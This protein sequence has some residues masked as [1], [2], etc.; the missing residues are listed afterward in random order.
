MQLRAGRGD[1]TTRRVDAIVNAANSSLARG[2]GVCGAI[3]AAAGPDLDRACAAI[4]GCAT[5]DAVATPGF[6]L[7]ARWIIHAVG[8]VWRGGTD[9]EAGQLASCYRRV[10]AVAGEIGARSVAIPAISTGI[11]GFPGDQ[12]AEIAVTTLRAAAASTTPSASTVDEVL[13]VAFDE[14]TAERYEHLL[15]SPD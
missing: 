11:F 12:A 14:A 10:L 9:D 4:G 7:P 15:A 13:L 3:F 6:E 2:G 8:P 5:G 1:I